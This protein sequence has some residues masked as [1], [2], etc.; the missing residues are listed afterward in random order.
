MLLPAAF[1][2]SSRG[3]LNDPYSF[4]YQPNLPLREFNSKVYFEAYIHIEQFFFKVSNYRKRNVLL[5]RGQNYRV[6][7]FPIDIFPHFKEG[8]K[9]DQPF[10]P[11]RILI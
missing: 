3:E 9:I 6:K 10:L 2:T 11:Y 8:E 5:D 7:I 1:I 4:Q